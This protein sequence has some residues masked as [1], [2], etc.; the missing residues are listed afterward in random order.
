M[1]FVSLDAVPWRTML[2]GAR[3]RFVHSGTMTVSHWEFEGG[4]ALPTHAHP[5]E[6]IT[7]CVSGRFELTIGGETRVL[8]AGDVAIIPPGAVHS[9]RAISESHLVDVFHPVR[10]D[11]R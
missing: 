7:T 2:K 8:G 6:Q 11:Y 5:H 1:P 10:E 9:G 4:T 3:A